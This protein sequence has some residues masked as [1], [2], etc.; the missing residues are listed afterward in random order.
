VTGVARRRGHQKQQNLKDDHFAIIE[1]AKLANRRGKHKEKWKTY[2]LLVSLD[3]LQYSSAGSA[4]TWSHRGERHGGRWCLRESGRVLG[5]GCKQT[6]GGGVLV[7]TDLRPSSIYFK[8]EGVTYTKSGTV[9]RISC[10]WFCDR[11]SRAGSKG[12][13]KRRGSDSL[14]LR[15]G[16]KRSNGTHCQ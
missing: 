2:S 6:R 16:D 11:K 5:P 4:T 1:N 8:D 15:G 14:A 13:R 9:S 7:L 10:S 12:V 3:R